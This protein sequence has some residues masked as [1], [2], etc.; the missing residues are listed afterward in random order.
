[1]SARILL[2]AVVLAVALYVTS[3]AR[4]GGWWTSIRLDRTKVAVGQEM[5]AHANVMFSSV[6]AVEAA[7]SGR[8]NEAFYVYLLRGSDYSVV[9]RALPKASPRNW[10]SPDSAAA[11]RVG[12]A[13]IGGGEL[14]LALAS[15][16]F[17]VPD[18]PAGNYSVMF[19][20]AGCTRPLADVIPTMPSQLTVVG[21]PVEESVWADALWFV[22]GALFGVG[23]A[24][25]FRW[26]TIRREPAS[27][28]TPRTAAL[29]ARPR[30]SSRGGR[31]PGR[32]RRSGETSSRRA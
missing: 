22:G 8:E 3:P 11:F 13:V 17:R 19:C 2:G 14:N 28:T 18:I 5:K 4:A 9:A 20:D 25:V 26:R 29:A 24:L 16:S 7:Q 12:R 27:W 15:A 6:D 30:S 23:L 32:R 10:W 1:L 21:K 31:S